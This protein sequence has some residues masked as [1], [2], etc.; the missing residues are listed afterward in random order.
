MSFYMYYTKRV[1]ISQACFYTTINGS[2]YL[3][4]KKT[5]SKLNLLIKVYLDLFSKTLK[6]VH[7]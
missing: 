7:F 6:K 3:L 5:F 1:F 4:L 2:I